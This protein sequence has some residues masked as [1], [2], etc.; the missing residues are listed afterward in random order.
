MSDDVKIDQIPLLNAPSI[1]LKGSASTLIVQDSSTLR[2]Q[3]SVLSSYIYNSVVENNPS[4]IP[5]GQ[6]A[7]FARS[8]RP[9][10]WLVCNGDLLTKSELYNALFDAIGT[11]FNRPT[12]TDNTKFRIPDLRG[13][14]I[15]SWQDENSG[16][17]AGREFG[18]YQ[19]DD[20]KSHKH[21][22]V[23]T[24]ESASGDEEGKLDVANND[25][26][27]GT[28][29]STQLTGG[30]ETRPK[31]IALL[32]CIRYAQVKISSI[33][34]NPSITTSNGITVK[35][36]DT[37]YSD[38]RELEIIG[39]EVSAVKQNQLLKVQIDKPETPV[40]N[41]SITEINTLKT[42]DKIVDVV[43]RPIIL[44][45]V[46]DYLCVNE[47]MIVTS[48]PAIV[49]WG[50][51]FEN[52]FDPKANDIW[53]P[54]RAR[55]EDNF[56]F[57]NRNI[58]ITKVIASNYWKIALMSDGSLWICGYANA[59]DYVGIPKGLKTAGFVKINTSIKFKDIDFASD[60]NSRRI[61]FAGI[62]IENKL[63]TWG[64]NVAGE[65]GHGHK[66]A[67]TT[68]T[69]VESVKTKDVKQVVMSANDGG[70]CN[71]KV[72]FTDGTL[73]AT[74]YNVHGQLG[75]NDTTERTTLTQC[76]DSSNN[77][78]T[79]IKFIVKGNWPNIYQ[80]AC[81]SN[82][83][84]VYTCGVNGNGNLGLGDKTN[85][86][87]YSQV[88]IQDNKKIVSMVGTGY[89]TNVS[90][91]A[92]DEDGR[93]YTWG[94]NSYGLIGNGTTAVQT[95]P[96]K[97]GGKVA[98]VRI[99][100]LY[101]SGGY[102]NASAFGCIDVNKNVWMC[103]YYIPDYVSY[104]DNYSSTFIK[105]P[106]NSVED[107]VMHSGYSADYKTHYNHMATTFLVE[108]NRIFSFGINGNSSTFGAKQENYMFP[109]EVFVS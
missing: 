109:V 51:N 108:N 70:R 80:G 90:Y 10:G 85:K 25:G 16:D 49:V 106:I 24:G 104:A 41:T 19:E 83:G 30:S 99:Q 31:N 43:R 48:D 23:D 69:L 95:T 2:V 28:I 89:S 101:S 71:M 66:N 7:F 65:C 36:G 76:K 105:M 39:T 42:T 67:I 54:Q 91:M 93:I 98:T 97:V 3:V 79:N 50:N 13:R 88:T 47:R 57:E 73:W 55:F 94:C 15:R 87:Y 6:I 32:A 9:E 82:D 34:T 62:S 8:T 103:G 45:L 18:S 11:T 64:V 63:Y 77:P 59:I 14:F 84:K 56:L 86:N 4:D 68:P 96:Y 107:M 58:K 20:F 27:T 44:G 75:V 33:I 1:P 78:I 26:P 22:I 12:D 74:G 37:L 60:D 35:V 72:L 21:D 100:K 53:P 92:L 17:D 61:S 102:G 40:V 46:Q 29:A 38:V 81:V 5:V 52:N